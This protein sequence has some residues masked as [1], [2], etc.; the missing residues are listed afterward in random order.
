KSVYDVE[1]HEAMIQDKTIVIPDH[2]WL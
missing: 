2:S 1:F